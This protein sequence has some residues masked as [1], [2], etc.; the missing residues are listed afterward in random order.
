MSLPKTAILGPRSAS[1]AGASM[2]PRLLCALLLIAPCSFAQ[3]ASTE[4]ATTNQ[5]KMVVILTRHGVRSPTG[6]ANVKDPWPKLQPDWGVDCCGDLTPTGKQLVRLMGTYYHEHYAAPAQRILP[7]GCPDKQVYIWA[8]NEERTMETG[9]ELAQGM[10]RGRPDCNIIVHSVG[11]KPQDCSTSPGD[12]FCQ[13]GKPTDPLFHLPSTYYKPD[14]QQMQ[15]IADHINKN[16]KQLV[17]KYS[18]PLQD[19]QDT[20]CPSK[21]CMLTPD[22]PAS[23]VDGKLSW[24]GRFSAGSTAAE[25]FLLE[26]GN[27]M[28]CNKVGWGRV[29][30]NSPDCSGPGELFRHMQEIHTAYFQEMQRAPYIAKIQGSNLTYHILQKL[31][32]GVH[33]PVGLQQKLVIF[34]GHDTN[35]ANVAAM[36]NLHW[37]LPDLPDDDTPPAGALVFELYSSP[38]KGKDFVRVHYVHQT[39]RQLRTRA[40]L[41]DKHPPNWVDL[42]MSPCETKCDFQKFEKILLKAIDQNFVTQNATDK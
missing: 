13:R 6:A 29:I 12:K 21:N 18:K 20:L 5:L 3:S 35:I 37:K 32:Q 17:E 40:A 36:L 30:F 1:G 19:L 16:Y 10:A 9:G 11:Y 24:H 28:P 8:D 27:G 33:S 42:T 31:R 34:S 41:T 4:Q 23:V 14:P 38:E 26:Y 39:V 2:P 22:Q 7:A 25:I 15:A